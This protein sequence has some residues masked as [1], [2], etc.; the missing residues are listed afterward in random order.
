MD[1]LEPRSTREEEEYE[2][3]IDEYWA[4]MDRLEILKLH[5]ADSPSLNTDLWVDDLPF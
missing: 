2:A 4:E 3:R 5:S 1:P